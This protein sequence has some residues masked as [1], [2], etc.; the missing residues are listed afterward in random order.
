[1]KKKGQW[2]LIIIMLLGLFIL[3]R[4]WDKDDDEGSGI[5]DMGDKETTPETWDMVLTAMSG[6]LEKYFVKPANQGCEYPSNAQI[7]LI[8]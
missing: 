6:V 1:M 2:N 4:A 8:T 3:G 5:F 7:T